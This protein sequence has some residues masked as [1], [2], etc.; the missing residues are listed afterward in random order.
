[1]VQQLG[2]L[3]VEEVIR[4]RRH[5]WP[6]SACRSALGARLGGLPAPAADRFRRKDPAPGNFSLP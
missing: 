6:I 3:A 1:M 5:F 2:I 4:F